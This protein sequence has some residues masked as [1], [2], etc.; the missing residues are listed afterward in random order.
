MPKNQANDNL[1]KPMQAG[2]QAVQNMVTKT[3][4]TH[5]LHTPTPWKQNPKSALVVND[6]GQI[7]ADCNNPNA[8]SKAEQLANAAFI[9]AACNSYYDLVMA[10]IRIRGWCAMN[11]YPSNHPLFQY[12]ETAISKVR[13]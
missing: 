11:H 5:D 12:A 7:I 6:K 3:I 4:T 2:L 10:L 1:S 13:V 9:V 8:F